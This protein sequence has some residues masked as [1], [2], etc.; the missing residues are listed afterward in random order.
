TRTKQTTIPVLRPLYVAILATWLLPAGAMAQDF[1]MSEAKKVDEDKVAELTQASS[2]VEGGFLYIDD[3]SARFG[4]FMGLTEDGAYVDLN[5]DIHKRG[6]YD[7]DSAKYTEITGRNLGL[8]Y[9]ELHFGFGEQG[10]YDLLID[11]SQIPS[12]NSDSAQTIF[13]GAGSTNLTLPAGWVGSSSTAGMTMLESS[14]RPVDIEQE[15]KR[16]DAGIHKVLGP[17][18]SFKVKYRHEEKE[19]TKTVGAV[20]GNSGGNP[21]AVILP[22]PV[23]YTTEQVDAV[24]GY[25]DKTKQFQV[26]YYLS[27]FRDHNDSL[28][29]QN[30]YNAIGGWDPSSGFA[31][32]GQG[33][34][35]LPPD[36]EFHQVS[37]LGGYNL[38]DTTRVTAD[39]AFG[40]MT[41]N[42][43]FLPYTI[44]PT[45][46]ATVTQPLPSDSLDGEINTTVVNLRATSRPSPMFR[47]KASYRYDDRDN[48]TPRR[49]FV[50]IGGDTT[51]QDTSAT[52]GRRRY[53]EP[54]SY[55]QHQY[56]FDASFRA[57][58]RTDLTAGV[59]RE[60]IDRTYTEREESSEDT[61]RVGLKRRFSD[62]FHGGVRYAR[63]KRD[64]ST[65]HGDHPF[66]SGYS[67]AYTDTQP[68]MWEN[69]PDLRKYYLADRTRDRATVF[70]NFTPSMYWSLGFNANYLKDDYDASEMGLTQSDISNYTFDATFMPEDG[71][72]FYAFFT[73]ED[74]GAKQDGRSFQGFAKLAQ[75]GDPNR[76]WMATHDDKTDSV[77][78]GFKRMLNA[79]WELGS[80]LLFANSDADV[81][82]MVGSGLSAEALPTTTTRLISLGLHA[83]YK[84]KKNVKVRFQYLYE[85]YQSE[86][87]AY[88]GVDPDTLANVITLG[89]D[90][91]NYTV[92]VFGISVSYR[93]F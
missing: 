90:T 79:Q 49:E 66:L 39:A 89:E 9:R 80:D 14:L 27:S 34:L 41:Q 32:G 23:D 18:W 57:D 3:S 30:P 28:A 75:A 5:V 87:W 2:V 60:D 51:N 4:R 74:L 31:S 12:F 65:Y 59:E 33:Q 26:A 25:A 36:N 76:D 10:N 53:N 86:D 42:D 73:H 13:N 63:A 62:T 37:L 40:R 69:H 1:S 84:P 52:S 47:W 20:M 45:L 68:G 17:N 38:S 72:T 88:D 61:F 44:N 46:A 77:G 24:L 81:E 83:T 8:D 15:R 11:Y 16:L 55:T 58:K 82:M 64:G 54:Y 67:E 91:P 35:G 21:R 22:E 93:Y 48:Q 92:N 78:F 85:D 7:G 43:A 56:R 71:T 29:W 6:P 70:A 19:G 50:Y